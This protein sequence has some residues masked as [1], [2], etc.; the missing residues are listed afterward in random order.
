MF[1]KNPLVLPTE[2]APLVFSTDIAH[3]FMLHI[4][5]KTGNAFDLPAIADPA[6]GGFVIDTHK[7]DATKVDSQAKGTLR[8]T[9]GFESY[10]GPA[11][12]LQNAHST[13]W[14]VPAEDQG[15]LIVGR[16]DT[17]HVESECAA[18]VEQISAKNQQGKILQ[19]RGSFRNRTS[20]R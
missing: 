4:E 15:G 13:T 2:G 17:L 19:Q 7:L 14:K 9:W 6:S 8:G 12:R 1:E 5:G 11:F 3:N 20:W 10:E 16:E 18:C